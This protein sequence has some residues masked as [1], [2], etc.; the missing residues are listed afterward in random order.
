MLSKYLVESKIFPNAY[1]EF[2]NFVIGNQ[3]LQKNNGIVVRTSI[4]IHTVMNQFVLLVQEL[5][6]TKKQDIHH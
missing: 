3:K 5:I 4:G 2:S 1:F 6:T